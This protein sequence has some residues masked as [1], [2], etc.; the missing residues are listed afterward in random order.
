MKN[1][2]KARMYL[3]VVLT[4]CVT[5]LLQ[6]CATGA[7]GLQETEGRKL[8]NEK[9]YKEDALSVDAV[10]QAYF[11]LMGRFNYPIPD[12]LKTDNFWLCDFNQGDIMALGMSG[13]F[14]IN[15]KGEYKTS[16]AGK[17]DGKFK[18]EKF[19][20]L[21]HEIYLLP[22][23]TLPEHRHI[24]GTEGYGPKMEAWQ[25][26]YG[27]VYF[28]GEYKHSDEVL[29]SEWPEELRPWG[30]GEDW[31]KSK[32]IAK[33]DAKTNQMYVM[34]DPESWH[35]QV[36]GKDGAIVTEVATYHNHVMFSKPGMEFK[37]TGAE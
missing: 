27:E 24:G 31:F 28:Y 23:Q 14:W 8:K 36:A 30:Y 16:G 19:G 9:F 12:I 1:R 32:Y 15:E 17:Y 11:D 20:Y 33:R 6:G 25:V 37:N 5:G 3:A 18:D 10:K 22:G 13:I 2:I 35:G 34:A 26:R 7:G 29:I 4:L 21:L